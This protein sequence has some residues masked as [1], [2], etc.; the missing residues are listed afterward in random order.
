MPRKAK[1]ETLLNAIQTPV[2]LITV[3]R[4]VAF[5]NQG[6][7][8]LTGWSADE[9]L[10]QTCDFTSR[11]DNTSVDS[12]TSLLCPPPEVCD[13]QYLVVPVYLVHR[14]G[15]TE[16]RLL[17][18]YPLKDDA[19]KIKTILGVITSLEQP[20]TTTQ[21]SP[22]QRLHAELAA[23][24]FSL[25]QRYS[26]KSIVCRSGAMKRVLEQIVL[27]RDSNLGILLSGESG[28]G[29]DHVA[30][31]I[32]YASE[33]RTR[34]FVPFECRHVPADRLKQALDSLL[35]TLADSSSV[36]PAIL[37]G[38]LY[39]CDVEYLPRDLQAMLVETLQPSH[40]GT[41]PSLRLMASSTSDLR[42]AVHAD[43]LRPDLFYLLTPVQIEIPALRS[44][45]NELPLLAQH[46]LEES[47]RGQDQQI[48]GFDD[49]VLSQFREYNWPGNLDELKDVISEARSS[50][51]NHL[52]RAK[53]LPFRF[54]TGLDAQ[55]VGPP[56][57]TTAVPLATLL[58][59]VEREQIQWALEQC[60]HDKTKA[61]KLLDVT[62]ARLYRRMGALEIDAADD[63]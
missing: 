22:P 20:A 6:C 41:R 57:T 38:T 39:L 19:G 60:R 63:A 25:R 10:G 50:C 61:A 26:V 35:E 12:V 54:R 14:D 21:V 13:G 36:A 42:D 3:A 8:R 53:D 44:R 49:Q 48:S 62:R 7:E 18:F 33:A 46:F 30:R 31:T 15:H 29:K 51:T 2:F 47:N 24:R 28:V 59:N 32:H 23:L 58:A 9:V 45:M 34:T 56:I 52:L 11:V 17:H 37:P 5:F 4:K 40:S 27:G 55:A 43:R 1:L 16:P